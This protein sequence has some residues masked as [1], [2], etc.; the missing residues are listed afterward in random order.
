[1]LRSAG[2]LLLTAILASCAPVGP[3]FVKPDAP[4][5]EEWSQPAEEGLQPTPADLAEWLQVFED[6]VLDQ[7][8]TLALEQN[9]NLEIAG[10]RVLK[11]LAQLGIATGSRYPQTQILAGDATAVSPANNT[12]VTSNFWQYGLGASAS[13]EIDFWE[14]FARGIE[15]ADACIPRIHC[16]L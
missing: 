5:P 6:P 13:W 7:L 10:L 16:R 12:G 3:D 11:A 15:S 9:N 8:M 1:M 14:R 4:L 2:C